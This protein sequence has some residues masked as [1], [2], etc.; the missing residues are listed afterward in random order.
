M[1]VCCRDVFESNS[2]VHFNSPCIA[3]TVLTSGQLS[4]QKDTGW[5]KA[6]IAATTTRGLAL[7]SQLQ[8]HT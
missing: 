2:Q 1:V 7:C 5:S 6:T 3:G 8:R 4:H